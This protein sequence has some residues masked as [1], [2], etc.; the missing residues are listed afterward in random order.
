VARESGNNADVSTQ[1]RLY[2]QRLSETDEGRIS[3][4]YCGFKEGVHEARLPT[5]RVFH[6]KQQD[7]I[8]AGEV[9]DYTILG[10]TVSYFDLPLNAE[11]YE[12]HPHRIDLAAE[13]VGATGGTFATLVA[14][15]PRPGV[16]MTELKSLSHEELLATV[17]DSMKGEARQ[18]NSELGESGS[19]DVVGATM[20]QSYSWTSGG[21]GGPRPDP[22][23][24]DAD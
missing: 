24:S 15:P 1:V 12:S 16:D 23:G 8:D 13:I 17:R 11:V 5:A 4:L 20:Y 19:P 18:G 3:L 9:P 6:F 22:W 10:E 7:V 14:T 21:I 2:G